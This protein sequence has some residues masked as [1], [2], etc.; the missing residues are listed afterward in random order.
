MEDSS[1]FCSKMFRLAIGGFGLAL[2][3]FTR[4]LSLPLRQEVGLFHGWG[5]V[6][7]YKR[8]VSQRG[9]PLIWTGDHREN[10]I[11]RKACLNLAVITAII[12]CCRFLP[13]PH[14]PHEKAPPP[15]FSS[16]PLHP[17]SRNSSLFQSIS[18]SSIQLIPA[19]GVGPGGLTVA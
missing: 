19:R 10:H 1:G 5:V 11:R 6:I 14:L 13:P 3:F 4:F 9:L 17:L 16:N 18:F 12:S 7:C 15:T 2:F 8:P